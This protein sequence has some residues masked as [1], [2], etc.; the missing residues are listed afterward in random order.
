MNESKRPFGYVPESDLQD[1][2]PLSYDVE[3]TN[4]INSRSPQAERHFVQRQQPIPNRRVGNVDGRGSS[5]RRS[6]FRSEYPESAWSRRGFGNKW[7]GR[8]NFDS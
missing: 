5:G 2:Q 6:D 7:R 4:R 1:I 3:K 8:V